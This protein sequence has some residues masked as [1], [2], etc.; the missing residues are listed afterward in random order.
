[1]NEKIEEH[2]LRLII[3]SILNSDLTMRELRDISKLLAGDDG[4]SLRLSNIINDILKSLNNNLSPRKNIKDSYLAEDNGKI[5]K[6]LSLIRR[7]RLSKNKV[8]SLIE[9]ISPSMLHLS[10]NNY[11]MHEILDTYFNLES[12]YNID[13]FFKR[14]NSAK[15]LVDDY[16]RGIIEKK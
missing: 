4:F 15:L 14:L 6:A 10:S 11:T 8:L 5:E 7:K 13:L 3:S 1:M 16:L 2:V 9:E 12:D